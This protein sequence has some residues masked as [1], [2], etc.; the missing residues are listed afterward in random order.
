LQESGFFGRES[1]CEAL[2]AYLEGQPAAI[3]FIVGPTNSGK[4]ALLQHVLNSLP[5]NDQ[6]FPAVYLNGRGAQISNEGVLTRSLQAAGTSAL[7]RL[8]QRLATFASSPQAKAFATW[9]SK[10]QVAGSNFSISGDDIVSAFLNAQ[11][12]KMDDVITVYNEMLDTAKASGS[13]WPIICIDEANALTKY[14]KGSQEKEALNS[15]LSF[16]VKVSVKCA[17]LDKE[18]A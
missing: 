6:A 12:Q 8:S 3:L 7:S 13:S 5:E 2:T 4:T 9:T 16:F 1:E 17:K 14:R 11:D 18:Q 10:E 15:L